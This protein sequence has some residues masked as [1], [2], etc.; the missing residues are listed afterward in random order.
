MTVTETSPRSPLPASAPRDVLMVLGYT[1]WS[2]AARRGWIHSED[3]L[4]RFL[5]DSP[6]VRRLLVCN[7]YRSAPSKLVR[8]ALGRADEPFPGDEAR[9]LHEPLRLRRSDPTGEAAVKRAV[10]GYEHSVRRAAARAGLERPA[11]IVAHP[12][13]AGFGT[14][15][16]ADPVT[17][18]A[19]D[20]LASYDGLRPWWPAY[21]SSFDRLRAAGR[22]VAAVTPA[23]LASVGAPGDVVP[24]GIEPSEWLAPG[25][26]PAWFA[27]LPSP[28][29]LYVG[30]LDFRLDLPHVKALAEAYRDAS[31]VLVGRCPEPA[32]YEALQAL[33]NV[34]IRPPV[35]RAELPGLVAA[36]DVGL[37][38]HVRSPLT[39][40]MSPLKLYEYLAAG[41]PVAATELA[42]V[43]GVSPGRVQ[44]AAT[45]V[46]LPQAVAQALA[47]GPWGEPERRRFIA[48]HAWDRRF[49]RLLDLAFAG[50]PRESAGGRTPF[51][52][53]GRHPADPFDLRSHARDV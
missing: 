27:S 19:T 13:V 3:R 41:L 14:F 33:P 48:D 5:L 24:N 9:Q 20:D 28:R 4:T 51:I 1:S 11:A 29:L 8:R 18:F 45:P 31:I 7:P 15:D 26:P 39:E 53:D 38:P 23:A 25:A 49:E 22:Q 10:A 37:I 52:P 32:R 44:L 6:R 16:W 17:Y 30:T 36:A 43:T 35:E 34:T 40:A 47:A 21:A 50:A 42:G 2:G 46:E 12:L